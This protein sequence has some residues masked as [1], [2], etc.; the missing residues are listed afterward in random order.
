FGELRADAA[1]LVVL[2]PGFEFGYGVGRNSTPTAA[3]DRQRTIA[4]RE[5]PSPA[6]TSE[7]VL[8]T[9]VVSPSA[10]RAPRSERLRTTHSSA[11]YPLLKD[12]RPPLKTRCL[13]SLR[14][15]ANT[16]PSRPIEF[17]VIGDMSLASLSDRR[18]EA[19]CVPGRSCH[20]GTHR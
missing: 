4:G 7:N 16:F 8:G 3:V 10:S 18:T 5:I 6:I 1:A 2:R 11:P 9:A 14:R 15:S 20:S 19:K 17:S 13:V 12:S